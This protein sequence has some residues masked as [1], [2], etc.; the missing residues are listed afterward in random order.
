MQIIN[1]PVIAAPCS[2]HGTCYM[3]QS[4]N[5]LNG[6]GALTE[7]QKS[8]IQ[9]QITLV[10]TL[11][12]S[13]WALRKNL[14]MLAIAQRSIGVRPVASDINTFVQ[15]RAALMDAAQRL[16]KFMYD[17]KDKASNAYNSYLAELNDFAASIAPTGVSSV[18]F[19]QI[20][21]IAIP[22]L[23][24][25]V[26]EQVSKDRTAEMRSELS[27][28]GAPATV[29]LNGSWAPWI[30]VTGAGVVCAGAL[31]STVLSFG[32]ATPVAV[33][34]CKI[35]AVVAVAAIGFSAYELYNTRDVN[36]INA[37]VEANKQALQ[38]TADC[39]NNPN[40]SREACAALLKKSTEE[41][42]YNPKDN[43]AGDTINSL[44]KLA[45]A[46]GVFGVGFMLFKSGVFSAGARAIDA[47]YALPA[48]SPAMAGLKNRR[49]MSRRRRYS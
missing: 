10:M 15:S 34:T 5:R 9:D 22:A 49:R 20:A 37:Q 16:D 21:G 42:M 30:T 4:K 11:F 12:A 8:K 17:N 35:A 7:A 23:P 24:E 28:Y 3:C 26:T 32:L 40:I 14:V 38:N 36:K 46:L 6:L 18:S 33:V 27:F 2:C 45:I 44:T 48:P 41:G 13:T 1:V 29:Q 31:A 43:G 39:Y 47:R 19:E 25:F